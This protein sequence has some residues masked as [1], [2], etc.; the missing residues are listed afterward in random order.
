MQAVRLA[1]GFPPLSALE[2]ILEC[3]TETGDLESALDAWWQLEAL[4]WE[5]RRRSWLGRRLGVALARAAADSDDVAALASA[6]PEHARCL[7][8][9]LAA[10]GSDSAALKRLASAEMV[11]LY[12]RWARQTIG[13]DMTLSRYV[14]A[15]EVGQSAPPPSVA[16]L[17]E[18]AEPVDAL[19]EW[20][21]ILRNRRPTRREAMAAA[22]LATLVVQNNSA[23]RMLRSGF[24][25]LGSVAMAG[26]PVD[27]LRAYLPLRWAEH[28]R[29]AAQ[30]T[31]LDPWLVA[32]VARQ[33]SVFTAHARSPAGAVGVL[34]LL[35]ETARL[36]SRAL[37]LGGRPDLEDPGVNIRLGARELAALLQ[38]FGALEPALA[39]YNAGGTRVRRWWRRW[40]NRQVF[41]ES[42]PIPETY[43]YIRRVVF[44]ADSY[45]LTYGEKWSSPP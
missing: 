37:G 38:K 5:D 30:E 21:R 24:P 22:E 27:A 15:S 25:E 9:W 3:G 4:G 13:I 18:H 45:R 39:A 32:A 28:I 34:Q 40:P 44:L 26:L 17:L 42:V 8:F 19:N 35:P 14:V 2:L 10:T 33:E 11:D 41:V 16:W 23:I 43:N 29:A 1:G 31:G 6:L 20:R 12:G 36:H 7:N